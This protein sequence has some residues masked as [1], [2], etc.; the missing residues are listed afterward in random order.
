MIKIDA[1]HAQ[2]TGVLDGG[3]N[4]TATLDGNGSAPASTVSVTEL[5]SNN[6]VDRVTVTVARHGSRHSG[7]GLSRKDNKLMATCEKTP[8]HWGLLQEPP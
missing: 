1:R 2:T 4:T 5:E 3:E 7:I 8:T 6:G